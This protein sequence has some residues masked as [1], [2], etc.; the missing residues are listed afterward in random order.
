MAYIENITLDYPNKD[1][2]QLK[3]H[4]HGH[5][6][7]VSRSIDHKAKI[8]LLKRKMQIGDQITVSFKEDN[9][10]KPTMYAPKQELITVSVLFAIGVA[11]IGVSVFAM[12]YFDLW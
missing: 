7:Y 9:P 2:N 1:K 12:D 4:P 5:I 11:L 3:K 10:E 6:S 8:L